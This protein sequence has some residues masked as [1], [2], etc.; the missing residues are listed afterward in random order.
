MP[1]I[2]STTNWSRLRT[3]AN[4]QVHAAVMDDPDIRPTGEAFWVNACVVTVSDRRM[5]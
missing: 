1:G 3:M 4:E 2:I 5:G